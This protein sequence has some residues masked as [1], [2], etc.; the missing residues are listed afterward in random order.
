MPLYLIRHGETDSNRDK[1]VQTPDTPL[2]SLGQRQAQYLA[3]RFIDT[4]IDLIL[5]SDY[6]RTQ[7]TA[8]PLVAKQ[9]CAIVLNDIL[10][11][12][13]FGDLRGKTYDEVGHDFHHPNYAPPNGETI[14]QFRYRTQQSW[15]YV[16][17]QCADSLENI[18]VMTHGL[19]LREWLRQQL[20][21]PVNLKSAEATFENT[22][23]IIVDMLD[24]KTVLSLCDTS[25]LLPL[26]QAMHQGGVA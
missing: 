26:G 19:V 9:G 3:Q 18:V 5:C 2:S 15:Q 4:K 25:H 1:I 23:V 6:W 22:S 11:E 16:L 12:R 8:K 10:R 20:Y 17:Q 21:V 24:K 13:N 7:Q 14:A